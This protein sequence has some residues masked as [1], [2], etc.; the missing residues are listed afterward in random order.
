LPIFEFDWG[1]TP[2]NVD[3]HLEFAAFRFHFFNHSAEVEEWTVIDFDGFA[4]FKI[5][6]GLFDV[7]SVR[8]LGFDSFDLFSRGRCRLVATHETDNSLSFS[9]EIPRTVNDTLLIIEKNHVDED[10]TRAELSIGYDFLPSP[11][12]YNLLHGHKDFMDILFHFL[13][14]QA[15]FESVFH[16]LLLP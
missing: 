9:D 4:L 15:L 10:V 1:V 12:L 11:D 5:D 7:F 13:G 8:D 3:R 16:F 2:K 6:F 14:F